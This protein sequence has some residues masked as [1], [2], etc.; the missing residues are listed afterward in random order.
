LGDRGVTRDD[1]G[2]E[3]VVD[4]VVVVVVKSDLL[5]ISEVSFLAVDRVSFPLL[6]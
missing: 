5:L 3:E 6:N 1:N 2:S 4:V